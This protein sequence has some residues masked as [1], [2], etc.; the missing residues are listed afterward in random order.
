VVVALAGCGSSRLSLPSNGF[1]SATHEYSVR[2]VEAAF[3]AHGI[4]LHKR[5]LEQ[6]VQPNVVFLIGGSGARV[7]SV[8]VKNDP[9]RHGVV[10]I[11]ISTKYWPRLNKTLY[12]NVGVGW[13][14]R[15]KAVEASLHELH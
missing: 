4:Q 5:N 9:T 13:V 14:A 1:H 8:W 3:A 15:G 11:G 7:V 6:H 12:G 2:Q 10:P